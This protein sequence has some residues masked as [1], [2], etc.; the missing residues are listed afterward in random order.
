MIPSATA[1][2]SSTVEPAVPAR[3]EGGFCPLTFYFQ[4]G[5]PILAA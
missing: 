4:D 1:S 2:G 3:P 5:K